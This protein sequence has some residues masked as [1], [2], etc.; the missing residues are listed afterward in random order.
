VKRAC[1]GAQRGRTVAGDLR[2]GD[3]EWKF[4]HT[5]LSLPHWKGWGGMVSTWHENTR[6]CTIPSWPR[7]HAS[8]ATLGP[9]WR[10]FGSANFIV[11][12]LVP[13]SRPC[14][15]G[16]TEQW[17]RSGGEATVW[18]AIISRQR[19][20]GMGRHEAALVGRSHHGLAR[21]TPAVGIGQ[22][23]GED[24]GKSDPDRWAPGGDD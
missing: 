6:Q 23:R 7:A 20:D 22:S 19:G 14:S 15:D 12:L 13:A 11:E 5:P 17:R 2:G 16:T 21:I 3:S 1:A 10:P 24:W 4:V 18:P 8:K 9:R